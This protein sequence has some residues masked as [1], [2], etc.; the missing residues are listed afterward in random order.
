MAAA[1]P[2]T[3]LS[4]PLPRIERR[5][6]RL[7]RRAVYTVGT[8]LL[9]WLVLAYVVAPMLWTHYEHHRRM[10][11]AP[12]T[13]FLATGVPGDPLNIALV[14]SEKQL[15]DA[16][17]RAG[18]K[19]ADK[20]TLK[21]SLKIA[22]SVLSNRA[23]DTA[24]VST[25]YLFGR[26]HDLA[27]ER[28]V[29]SSARQRNH[30]RF[31]RSD[32]LGMDG[33]PLW[34]GAATFDESVG[35]SHLTGQITHHIAPDVDTERDRLIADLTAAGQLTS[36]FQVTGVGPTLQ[37]RNGGGDRYYTDGELTIATISPDNAVQTTPPE[38][39]ANPAI[40]DWKN[41]IVAWLRSGGS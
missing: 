37:G 6:R 16:M 14:G 41:Q 36:V 2:P 11:D 19:A 15:V 30:V 4:T 38:Q 22:H 3:A 13:T 18:W 7:L 12:K 33:Q 39:L 21:S 29:G 40:D 27:F 23:Y 25:L 32:D 1:D 24:P 34:L 31:W 20:T 17:I 35:V 26:K 10:A 28:P 5:R 8:L 9:V